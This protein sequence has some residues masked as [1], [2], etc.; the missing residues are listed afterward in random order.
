MRPHPAIR[1]HSP[2]PLDGHSDVASALQTVVDLCDTNAGIVH[3]SP[4]PQIV[5]LSTRKT[6]SPWSSF[7]S[8]SQ[9]RQKGPARRAA[10]K[11]GARRRKTQRYRYTSA[12]SAA[13]LQ[14]LRLTHFQVG[15]AGRRQP[16]RARKGGCMSRPKVPGPAPRALRRR[17]SSGRLW[18]VIGSPLTRENHLSGT[19]P[20]GQR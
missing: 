4:C 10:T 8:I 6:H 7:A 19:S 9:A 14:T 16:I 11:A 3:R 20:G 5:S 1:R 17:Q 18:L 12:T 15:S 2:P 13:I